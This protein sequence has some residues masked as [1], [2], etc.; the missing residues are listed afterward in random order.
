MG[1]PR[2]LVGANFNS[3]AAGIILMESLKFALEL[4]DRLLSVLEIEL[5]LGSHC[6][7]DLL[8]RINRRLGG[9]RPWQVD[10]HR[11]FF[12]LESR[13]DEEK[14]EQ[15]EHHINKGCQIE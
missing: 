2:V 3:L 14:D 12:L 8:A 5:S 9:A 13:D 6:D 11:P 15:Q 1:G 10:F 4:G 7:K